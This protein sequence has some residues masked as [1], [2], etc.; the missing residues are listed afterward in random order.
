[1]ILHKIP[2]W[3]APYSQMSTGAFPRPPEGGR[4]KKPTNLNVRRIS[5]K[6]IP[7]DRQSCFEDCHTLHDLPCKTRGSTRKGYSSNGYCL[8]ARTL[9]VVGTAHSNTPATGETFLTMED[10]CCSTFLL[11]YQI[12]GFLK[13]LKPI[14]RTLEISTDGFWISRSLF[15]QVLGWQV[16]FLLESE[17]QVD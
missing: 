5:S 16:F 8:P 12:K 10:S 9:R 7:G 15:F 17:M 6:M 14:Q 1:M 11:I 4:G 2:C 13:T 3:K